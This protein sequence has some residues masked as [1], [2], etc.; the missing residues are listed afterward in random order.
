MQLSCVGRLFD[1]DGDLEGIRC[2]A[3]DGVGNTGE[4]EP[5]EAGS[6]QGARFEAGVL[7]LAIDVITRSVVTSG[8]PTPYL[9]AAE[10]DQGLRKIADGLLLFLP[11]MLLACECGSTVG[12]PALED[13]CDD[14]SAQGPED[15]DQ[16]NKDSIHGSKCSTLSPS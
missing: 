7:R 5:Q 11:M 2:Q 13:S 9:S 6:A 10:L 3:H 14:G 12:V 16:R 8:G 4:P 15:S 1:D